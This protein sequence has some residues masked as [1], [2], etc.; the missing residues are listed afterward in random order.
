M[1]KF[2][3][4]VLVIV[5]MMVFWGGNLFAAEVNDAE[6]HS[7]F[8]SPIFPTTYLLMVDGIENGET[9]LKKSRLS[10]RRLSDEILAGVLAGIAT[11]SA[12]GYVG[13]YIFCGECDEQFWIAVTTAYS[14]GSAIGVYIVGN[15]GDKT[16]SFIA[17]LGGS[18][19]G[20][21]AG[22]AAAYAVPFGVLLLP[23]GPPIGATI[24]FNK[25]LRYKSPPVSGT[26]LINFRDGQMSLAVPAIY[27]RLDSFD[28][29]IL[30][31]RVDLV[32]V[33]F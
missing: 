28:G 25:T 26:A 2:I 23:L 20:G 19:L 4:F 10:D 9:N 1:F 15:I 17:T 30:T 12:V 7:S 3:S 8:Q 6:I 16:G 32:R 22:F 27:P 21:L 13:N 24:G 33:I 11:G 14:L 5:F 29:R 31:Q 18:M